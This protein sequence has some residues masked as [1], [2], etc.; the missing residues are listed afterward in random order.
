MF[1]E[2]VFAG[3]E[4]FYLEVAGPVR[5]ME[6]CMGLGCPLGSSIGPWP[7]SVPM[8]GLPIGGTDCSATTH[9]QCSILTRRAVK[10]N[11]FQC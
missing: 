7:C 10:L 8:V 5:A 11:K 4:R 6:M 3:Q 9:L 1:W 2:E